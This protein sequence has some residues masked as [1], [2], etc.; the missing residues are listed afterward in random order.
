MSQTIEVLANGQGIAIHQDNKHAVI[1]PALVL[2]DPATALP[3][4]AAPTLPIPVTVVNVTTAAYAKSLII[5]STAGSLQ[6][7]TGFNS[8]PTQFIHVYDSATVP[9][10]NA[11]PVIV[12]SVLAASNFSYP[13]V[14][15]FVN[16][17]VVASSS[18]GPTYT[19]ATNNDCWFDAQVI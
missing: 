6:Y 11:I 19:A 17:I 3:Y 16:G 12:M 8:G 15:S 2:L 13:H 5:K 1:V 10:N 14:R 18:T 4:S 9:N 7:L